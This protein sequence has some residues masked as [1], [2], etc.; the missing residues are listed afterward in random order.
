MAN[1]DK[2]YMHVHSTQLHACL[3]VYDYVCTFIIFTLVTRDSLHKY[4]TVLSL[5]MKEVSH[6]GV[7]T[8]MVAGPYTLSVNRTRWGSTSDV[9]S[10]LPVSHLDV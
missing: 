8:A 4:A 3:H 10:G 1:Y 5:I 7:R 9:G 2:L 6:T